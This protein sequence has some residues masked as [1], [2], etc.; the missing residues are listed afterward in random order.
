MEGWEGKESGSEWA[1]IGFIY[2]EVEG[3]QVLVGGEGDSFRS[4]QLRV[5]S[6]RLG[7]W[8]AKAEKMK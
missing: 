2:R 1:N 4:G 8:T 7:E 6:P 3:E 5:L